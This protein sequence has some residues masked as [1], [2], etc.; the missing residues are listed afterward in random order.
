MNPFN[1]IFCL[2]Y[3]IYLIAKYNLK[4][5]NTTNDELDNQ[6]FKNYYKK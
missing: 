2:F 1:F 6:N 5:D 4:Y 3:H